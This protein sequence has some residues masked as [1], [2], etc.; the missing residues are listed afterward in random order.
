M[1]R[2][3]FI[4][5]AGAVAAATG[6]GFATSA[7]GEAGPIKIGVLAPLTGVVA[8][9]GKEM[10]E[11][12]N[13]YW[14]QFGRKIAGREIQITVEDDA[15]NPDTALQKARRLVEQNEVHMLIGDLLA[16]TGL[17][18]AEY[19]KGNGVPYFIPI[20]AADDLTQRKRIPNVVRI[21][22]YS[23]SQDPRPLADWLYKKKG[24]RKV[25]TV[26]QDY[27]F[28]HEQC[29]G[30]VQVFS[31]LGG[32]VLSQY[33]HPL[34]TQDFSPYLAQIQS[35]NPDVVYAMETG[36]DGTRFIQQWANFGLKGKIPLSGSMNLTDQSIIRTLGS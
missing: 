7:R 6:T 33:W 27:T 11:A 25:I 14:N 29:G 9:G 36:A 2:R 17:A 8:S 34:N 28:G 24:F 26:S 32:K 20:I 4:K 22:G 30:F 1:D 10:V 19:V 16:N 18:V 21:A 5:A 23:A 35:A 13:L 31:G 15:S 3:N 12:F